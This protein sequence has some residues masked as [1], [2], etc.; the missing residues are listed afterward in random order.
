MKQ[1]LIAGFLIILFAVSG[2]SAQKTQ[3]QPTASQSAGD[4]ESDS[5]IKKDIEISGFVF[6]PNTLTI[7]SGT[8]VVWANMD[9]AAHTIVSDTGDEINSDSISKGKTYVHI[10]NASGIYDYHCGIHP[11]MKGKII[12]E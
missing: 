9:S 8:S 5:V 1:M 6:N 11:S 10:F 2:C 3:A 12:V 7:S 4:S